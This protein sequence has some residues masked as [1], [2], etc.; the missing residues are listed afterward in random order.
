MDQLQLHAGEQ[1]ILRLRKHPLIL[2]GKLIPLAILDYIPYL[3]PELGKFITATGPGGAIDYA[4]TL[5]FD[6][7][8]VRFVVGVYWLFLWMAAFGIFTNH[9]LDEWIVT[10]ERIIDIDQQAFWRRQV[11]SLFLDRIQNVETQVDGFFNT[12]FHF[13][14]VSVE[15]AGAEVN[16]IRMAGLANPEHVRDVILREHARMEDERLAKAPGV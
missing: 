15:S 1:I 4:A 6:N 13:G 9:Y 14:T 2:V 7:P 3:L 12:L 16:R 10:N 5:S 8:W 11:S